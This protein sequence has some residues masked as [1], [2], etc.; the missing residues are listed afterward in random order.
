MRTKHT[1]VLGDGEVR[2]ILNVQEAMR[3]QSLALREYSANP[4]AHAD[5]IALRPMGEGLNVGVMPGVSENKQAISVKVLVRTPG[6]SDF[7][8]GRNTSTIVMLDWTT[9]YPIALISG[10]YLTSIRTAATALLAAQTLARTSSKSVGIYGSGA[11]ARSIISSIGVVGL[12]TTVIAYSKS[13]SRK[14][15]L[16]Q[17]FEG[18]MG[19]FRVANQPEEVGECDIVFAASDGFGVG[20]DPSKLAHG[21]TIVSVSSRKNSSEIPSECFVGANVVVDSRSGATSEAAEFITDRGSGAQIIG[22]LGEVLAEKVVGRRRDDERWIFKA[23]GLAIQDAL[24]AKYLLSWA[25]ET[26]R[27]TL[28]RFLE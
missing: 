12:P 27:G 14:D 8:L 9:G 26:Q 3:I 18:S 4:E 7:G 19:N 13:Q 22:E 2:E 25:L 5:R 23:T 11:I 15:E 6:N 28:L 24:G 16:V 21:A 17:C 10:N 1:L 20:I